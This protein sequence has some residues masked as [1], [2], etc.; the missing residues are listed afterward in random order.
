MSGNRC[1]A[2]RRTALDRW[3]YWRETAALWLPTISRA[4]TSESPDALSMV[5]ALC[6]NEWKEISLGSRA[7]ERPCLVFWCPRGSTNPASARISLN[8]LES[9][10]VLLYAAA[11]GKM[12]ALGL[13][14]VGNALR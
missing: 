9:E 1:M 6:R 11:F 13:S 5:T 12:Y 8:W 4:N 10:V 7:A 14:L 2:A 3:V